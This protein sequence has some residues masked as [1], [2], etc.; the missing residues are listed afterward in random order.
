MYVYMKCVLTN[1]FMRSASPNPIHDRV[2][3]RAA[4]H[5]GIYGCPRKVYSFKTLAFRFSLSKRK[6]KGIK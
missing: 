4:K 3:L 2:G 6:I 1:D 5:S